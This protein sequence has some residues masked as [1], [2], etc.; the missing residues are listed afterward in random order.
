MRR[1]IQLTTAM[2]IS[3]CCAN[4]LA[5]PV[6]SPSGKAPAVSLENKVGRSAAAARII[7][8]GGIELP[9][10]KPAVEPFSKD[11][12]FVR[13]KFVV[14]DVLKGD[15][16]LRG[17]T[18][19]LKLPIILPG[20]AAAPLTDVQIKSAAQALQKI[21]RAYEAGT[22]DERAYRDEVQASR[23]KLVQSSSYLQQ[24]V[25]VPLRIGGLDATR[26]AA[27]VLMMPGESYVLMI[28]KDFDAVTA[29]Q[30]LFP[31]ELD[32][33]A[34]ADSQQLNSVRKSTGQR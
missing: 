9:R 27:D 13:I 23:G 15:A 19:E 7:A 10:Q 1:F 24:F 22:V 34:A 25:L 32:V 28:L 29:G 8:V 3:M 5:E 21:E 12:A 2:V 31:W 4:V 20:A 17:K 26:R 11:E 14:A 18:I 6:Y 33:Y 16:S 30:P